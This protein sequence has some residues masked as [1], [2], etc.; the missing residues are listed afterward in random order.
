MTINGFRLR[1]QPWP[2][3]ALIS[4]LFMAACSPSSNEGALTV[5]EVVQLPP[6]EVHFRLESQIE[7]DRRV[8]IEEA[9]FT[10][11]P[12]VQ[13]R[14][15]ANSGV[16][17]IWGALITGDD[18]EQV[19]THGYGLVAGT[20]EDSQYFASDPN[21][22]IRRGLSHPEAEAYS[23]AFERCAVEARERAGFDSDYIQMSIRVTQ[24]VSDLEQTIVA[25]SRL[26]E[27]TARWSLCMSDRGHT[28][29]SLSDP[30]DSIAMRLENVD[31][32]EL[33]LDSMLADEVDL[34]NDDLECRVEAEVDDV[35]REVR[36]E[37]E[38]RLFELHGDLLTEYHAARNGLP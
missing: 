36:E 37:S 28:V 26:S 18:R 4:A 3:G 30:R 33:D 31:L 9:G 16:A 34:A 8:C 38:A 22:H 13:P 11:V 35:L 2:A 29:R 5:D 19:R 7:E 15:E 32:G 17:R 20:I 10:Y 21:V 12:H 27:P 23:K 14:F 1:I 24:L 6:E 25:D